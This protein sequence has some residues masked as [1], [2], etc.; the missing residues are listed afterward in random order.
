MCLGNRGEKITTTEKERQKEK[1]PLSHC[2]MKL[3]PSGCQGNRGSMQAMDG[4]TFLVEPGSGNNETRKKW[5]PIETAVNC[6]VVMSAITSTPFQKSIKK[7]K[8]KIGESNEMSSAANPRERVALAMKQACCHRRRNVDSSNYE[9][10]QQQ[11]QRCRF[12]YELQAYFK[13]GLPTE[14]QIC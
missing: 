5:T 12:E 8:K 4:V 10:T 9:N 14:N 7:E 6:G 2:F 11:Q 3:C 1:Q 13:G